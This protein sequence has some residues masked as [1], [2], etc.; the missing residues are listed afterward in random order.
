MQVEVAEEF[1][2]EVLQ[3]VEQEEAVVEELTLVIQE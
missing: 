2:Q 1:D 3:T